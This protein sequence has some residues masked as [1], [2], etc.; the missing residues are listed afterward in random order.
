VI[1]AATFAMVLRD[2]PHQLGL[3]AAAIS[4]ICIGYASQQICL[5]L[6]PKSVNNAQERDQNKGATNNE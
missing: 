4:G 3:V 1:S 5:R 2:L 6:S